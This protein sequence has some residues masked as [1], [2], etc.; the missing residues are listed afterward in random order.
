[1][2]HFTFYMPLS[3][4][5][6]IF[7][8]YQFKLLFVLLLLFSFILNGFF[9][10]ITLIDANETVQG[11]WNM[12]SLMLFFYKDKIATIKSKRRK[13]VTQLVQRT[14]TLSVARLILARSLEYG[15][16]DINNAPTEQN[17]SKKI[18]LN[19][20]ACLQWFVTPQMKQ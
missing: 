17:S 12:Q 14:K 9:V 10:K 8:F 2:K 1:M 3:F 13:Q 20:W 15:D 18:M 5:F 6:S 19:F 7:T 11:I 4:N 16:G